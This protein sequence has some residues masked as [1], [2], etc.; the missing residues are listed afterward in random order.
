MRYVVGPVSDIP[1]GHSVVVYPEK[2]KDGIGVFNIDGDF[3]ALKNTCPHMG[4][5]LCKGTV[6]GTS[7]AT[8]PPNRAPE[9][10]WVRDGE[11]V[12][13]PWHHWEFEIR[14]GR[15]IFESK[16]RVRPYPVT[17]EPAEVMERLKA[18]AETIPVAVEDASI[19]LEI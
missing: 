18:G 12:S 14:T 4:G 17:V 7:T 1:R 10:K 8:L 16:Q 15:T 3:F 6:R 2:V 5:P 19:V 11:I 9:M 13:C